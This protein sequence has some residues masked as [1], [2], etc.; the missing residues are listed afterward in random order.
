MNIHFAILRLRTQLQ[1]LIAKLKARV[2]ASPHLWTQPGAGHWDADAMSRHDHSVTSTVRRVRTWTWRA[3]EGV[4]RMIWCCTVNASTVTTHCDR[5]ESFLTHYMCCH[6][7][8]EKV[9]YNSQGLQ[10]Q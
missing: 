3:Y 6:A 8:E 4:R 7:N 1:L 10:K 2:S 5:L 9:E